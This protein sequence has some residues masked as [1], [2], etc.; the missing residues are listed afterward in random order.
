M[1]SREDDALIDATPLQFAEDLQ[2]GA[3]ID[4]GSYLVERSEMV[5]FARKW[6]PQGFHIDDF[7]AAESTFGEIIAS[8]L[9]TMAVFQRLAVLGACRYWAIVAGRAIRDVQFI[10][11]VKEGMRLQATLTITDVVMTHPDRA[12]VT[13]RGEISSSTSIMTQSVDVYV[14]RRHQTELTRA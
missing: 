7:A 8:G 10:R 2:V 12:L 5:D 6:D 14:R 11:P 4:L 9:Y 3:T 13:Q 1:E